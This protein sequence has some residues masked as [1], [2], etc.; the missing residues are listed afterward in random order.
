M[1]KVPVLHIYDLR[2]YIS[3]RGAYRNIMALTACQCFS[4][5][6][7][8]IACICTDASPS[9][10][11]GVLIGLLAV[12]LMTF[13]VARYN[14]A[15]LIRRYGT[16]GKVAV[17]EQFGD[18]SVKV[19]GSN[20]PDITGSITDFRIMFGDYPYMYN[21]DTTRPRSRRRRRRRRAS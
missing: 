14:R 8:T 11:V 17:V 21:K 6:A 5:A 9:I 1:N 20:Y 3:D 15:E 4:I 7:Y 12:Q 19:I 16:C 13:T 10:N 18:I 2:R